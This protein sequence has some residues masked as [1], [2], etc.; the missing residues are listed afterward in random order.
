M[1]RYV[2]LNDISDGKLYD[3]DDVFTIGCNNCTG[4][5]ECCHGK[6]DTIVLNPYDIYR[7]ERGLRTDFLGLLDSHIGLSVYD[8]IILPHMMLVG[9]DEHCTF[10]D[11]NGRCMIHEYRPDICRLFPLG[12]I[13]QDGGHKYFI[14]THECN[15][16]NG[17]EKY[18]VRQWIAEPDY[19]RYEK[20]IDD[21]HDFINSILSEVQK[22]GSAE[23]IRNLC[24]VI[25]KK[26]YMADY[27][28][29][30]FYDRFYE[31]LDYVRK[32]VGM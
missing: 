15:R 30:D 6:A 29:G 21:W 24:M 9:D 20:F 31:I 11:G 10:I 13:Y 14:Q 18:T 1:K 16:V 12:R 17:S 32:A 27:N 26:F 19:D 4:C 2:S 23:D 7:L 3:I 5:G 25:I 28:E 22:N 8:G